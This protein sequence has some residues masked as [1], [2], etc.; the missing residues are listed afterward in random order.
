M[1]KPTRKS[2]VTKLDTVF[3]QYIRR[4]DAVNEIATCVTCGK[5][6]HYKK[7]QCGHFMSRRHYS[8]RWEENNVG[9]Q[10]YGCNITNQGMQYAFSKYLTKIDNKLPDE[11]LIKSKQ[12]VKFADVDLIDMINK[13]NLLLDSL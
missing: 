4:K 7:L 3:S 11:L 9:V 2:L 5:K 6:D 8:T 1:K 13:Y 10:C 12:I